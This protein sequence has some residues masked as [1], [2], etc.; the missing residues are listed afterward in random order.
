[1]IN[2]QFALA[3]AKG[4]SY[5]NREDDAGSEGLRKSK[6][7]YYPAFLETKFKVCKKNELTVVER[8]HFEEGKSL[9]SERIYV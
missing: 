8:K 4:F 3:N 6:L 1:M 2:R 9:Y 7:S 5:V